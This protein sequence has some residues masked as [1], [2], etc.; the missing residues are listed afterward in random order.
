MRRVYFD[1]GG[2]Y[3]LMDDREYDL[4]KEAVAGEIPGAS[5]V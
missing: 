4:L 5:A 1:L 2:E 3:N